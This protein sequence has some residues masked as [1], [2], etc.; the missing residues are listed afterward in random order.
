MTRY[1]ITGA[2]SKHDLNV[3]FF[4]KIDGNRLA[5]K[6]DIEGKHRGVDFIK[7]VINA[8][9]WE[10]G[11]GESWCFEGY[12]PGVGYD[13]VNGYFCTLDRKGWICLEKTADI[14]LKEAVAIASSNGFILNGTRSAEIL[15]FLYRY[16]GQI[17]EFALNVQDSYSVSDRR[18][19]ILVLSYV[20]EEA[21]KLR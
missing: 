12:V 16:P 18:T 9:S 2:P 20:I 10:D 14:T 3:R 7:V 5:V 17:A 15:K 19:P 11:S 21:L 8:V 1:N 13:R 4:N 6:F